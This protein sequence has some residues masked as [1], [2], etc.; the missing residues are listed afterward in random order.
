MLI[1]LPIN[2]GGKA[3][4]NPAAIAAVLPGPH[5][6]NC[7]IQLT[8]YNAD[9]EIGI[10]LPQ[11]KVIEMVTVALD[12]RIDA[13]FAA[14]FELD[15]DA[16]VERIE[17]TLDHTNRRMDAAIDA[18]VDR[19]LDAAFAAAIDRRLAAAI[20]AAID[21][22]LAVT[23]PAPQESAGRPPRIDASLA[24]RLD[25]AIDDNSDTIGIMR[26]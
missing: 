5:S 19:R 14:A 16:A 23:G 3:A 1:E 4:I 12:R 6:A 11:G 7:G 15:L 26:P 9:Q 13:A 17:A 10:A 18:A 21:R 25:A 8:G 22:R 2:G 20:D 24:A